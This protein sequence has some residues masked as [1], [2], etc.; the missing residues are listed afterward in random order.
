[1]IDYTPADLEKAEQVWLDMNGKGEFEQ[2]DIIAAAIAAERDRAT[3]AERDR[4]LTLHNTDYDGEFAQ[5]VGKWE[6]EVDH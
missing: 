4:L 1:M 5:E 2:M 3:Y 6:T